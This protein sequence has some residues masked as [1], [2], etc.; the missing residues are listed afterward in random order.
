M[1]VMRVTYVPQRTDHTITYAF[2]GERITATVN[3]V[4]DAFDFTNLPDGEGTEIIS[5]L[6]PCPVLAAKRVDGELHVTLLRAIPARPSDPEEL[7]AWRRL[8]TDDLEVVI[9]G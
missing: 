6:N 1:E 9:G 8:W 4:V 3:G 7:E 2:D 5:T